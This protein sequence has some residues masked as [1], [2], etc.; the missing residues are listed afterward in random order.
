MNPPLRITRDTLIPIGLMIS[1]FVGCIT[2]TWILASERSVISYRINNVE[3]QTGIN[4]K[5]I[6][7]IRLDLVQIQKDIVYQT[8]VIERIEQVLGTTGPLHGIRPNEAKP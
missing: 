7:M 5:A 8:R 1:L 3:V 4:T 6:E 2:G